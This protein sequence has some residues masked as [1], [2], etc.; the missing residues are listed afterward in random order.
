M[1]QSIATLLFLLAFGL[2]A[3]AQTVNGVPIEDIDVEYIQ[4]VGTSK[5]MSN[6]L[7]IKVDFGQEDKMFSMKD[8]RL[9]DADG[10]RVKFNSMIDALNFFAES[11]YEFVNAYAIDTGNRNVYHYMLR[12]KEGVSR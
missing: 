4:I 2:A 9:K 5:M 12:R 11:G 6:K 3:Q 10:K 7:T 1:K 8:Q